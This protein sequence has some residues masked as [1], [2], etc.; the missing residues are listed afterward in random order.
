MF[1]CEDG[2][3][4]DAEITPLSVEEGLKEVGRNVPTNNFGAMGKSCLL[5]VCWPS[6]YQK[7]LER[8]EI[9]GEV[10]EDVNAE[11]YQFTNTESGV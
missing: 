7:V 8:Y 2:F 4:S 3:T 10:P 11:G 1:D 6:Q 9:T 5:A